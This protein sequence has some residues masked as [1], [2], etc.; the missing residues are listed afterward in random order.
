MSELGAKLISGSAEADAAQSVR[1]ARREGLFDSLLRVYAK[2]PETVCQDCARCCFE[3]PGV[4]YTEYLYLLERIRALSQ[5]RR[6]HIERRAF[7]ELFFSWIES[8]SSCIFLDSGR[9]TIYDSRPLACRLF[10]LVPAAERDRAEAEARLAARQQARHLKRLG[11]DIPDEVVR[12]SLASCDRVRDRDG[13]PLA[14]DADAYAAR[15]A[16]LDA[17]LLP[18]QVVMDEFCFRSLPERLGAA[19][20]GA[21]AI[22][23]LRVQLLRR[24]QAGAHAGELVSLVLT[25]ARLPWPFGRSHGGKRRP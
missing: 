12:R 4:F 17:A 16:H 9:C 7:R 21:E 23:G 8:D 24:A 5:S 18:R 3:S 19:A 6:A 13:R 25:K 2:L 11:I 1:R 22:D 10:G 15:I 14:V 20:L